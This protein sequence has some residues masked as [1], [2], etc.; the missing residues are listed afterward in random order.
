MPLDFYPVLESRVVHA[1]GTVEGP[2][3]LT[4]ALEVVLR[5][6]RA[7]GVD[8]GSELRADESAALVLRTVKVVRRHR[9]GD[10]LVLPC[11][12][13]GGCCHA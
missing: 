8:D 5:M 4:L 12:G 13:A 6:V 2:A 1:A 3:M 9:Q 7:H 11:Q 10:G